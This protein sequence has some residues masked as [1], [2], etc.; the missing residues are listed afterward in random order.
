MYVITM[1]NN[2][3]AHQPMAQNLL[4]IEAVL[5][6]FFKVANIFL[7]EYLTQATSRLLHFLAHTKSLG[8]ISFSFFSRVFLGD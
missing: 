6:S 7:S 8:I 4:E 2:L 5:L 3:I 1:M